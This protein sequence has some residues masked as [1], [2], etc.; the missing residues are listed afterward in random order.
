MC[1]L[2]RAPQFG[3]SV[4]KVFNNQPH[5]GHVWQKCRQFGSIQQPT[6]ILCLDRVLVLA[7]A[8]RR[9]RVDDL[10][11]QAAALRYER[12]GIFEQ[13]RAF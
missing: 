12:K 2:R 8:R 7:T 3:D 1:A 5:P 10:A 11:P 13:Y 4:S 9:G 6:G